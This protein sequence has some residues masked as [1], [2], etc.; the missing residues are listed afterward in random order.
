MP[1]GAHDDSVGYH[2]PSGSRVAA[3]WKLSVGRMDE[4]PYRMPSVRTLIVR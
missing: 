2:R 3:G 4:C 1:S